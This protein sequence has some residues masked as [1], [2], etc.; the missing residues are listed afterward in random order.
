MLK[1][2]LLLGSLMAAAAG[3]VLYFDASFAPYY[4][5]LLLLALAV[6]VLATRELAALIPA[7]NRPRE[8]LCLLG[9]S[10]L[11]LLPFVQHPLNLSE[12][13][14]TAE[15]FAAF[16]I[17]ALLVEMADYREPGRC[18]GRA[19]HAVF[20]VG[21]LG[22]LPSFFLMIRWLPSEHAVWMLALAIFVPKCCDIGAYFTGRLIGRHPMTPRL[23]PKKTWEGLAG[24]LAFAVATAVIA[25]QFVPVFRNGI[26][27]AAAFGLVV[28][29]AGV[30][31]DLA[32]SLIKRDGLSKDASKNVPGFGGVLDVI[33]SILF[34][35]PVAYLWFR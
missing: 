28:G 5:I 9:V 35:G 34:A 25:G 13:S 22:L 18:V 29:I 30:L 1:I 7:E 23:S 33:D 24:G 6:G 32:E 15:A 8:W 16:V 14:L 10:V 19:A 26:V 3:G 12:R 21:Y 20:A 27:E 31:G 2:R 4:P 17:L 11:I